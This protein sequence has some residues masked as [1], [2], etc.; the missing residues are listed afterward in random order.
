M[1]AAVSTAQGRQRRKGEGRWQGPVSM[2]VSGRAG[3]VLG[4]VP[5]CGLGGRQRLVSDKDHTMAA[6]AHK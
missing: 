1:G 6:E 5:G 4:N 2:Q 3:A